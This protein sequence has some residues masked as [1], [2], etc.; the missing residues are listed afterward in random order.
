MCLIIV[1]ETCRS[2]ESLILHDIILNS[3]SVPK[4]IIIMEIIIHTVT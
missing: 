4:S 1:L 2:G 3:F